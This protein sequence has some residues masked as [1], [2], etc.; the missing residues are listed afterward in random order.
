[1]LVPHRLMR[2]PI[3][4]APVMTG[5]ATK[6]VGS[7]YLTN[8]GQLLCRMATAEENIEIVRQQ[9]QAF[10]RGDIEEM[11]SFWAAES[12]NHGGRTA[13]GEVRRPMPVGIDGVKRVFRSL[14]TAFPDRAHVV[15]DIFATG[16]RVVCR[17]TMR[18]TH[19]GVP[20]FPVEGGMLSTV[21][22]TGKSYE[23]QHIHIFRMAEGKITE[24]W[25]ARDD[26][27]L[28]QQLGIVP[29]AEPPSHP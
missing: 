29:M 28:M 6:S 21:P 7:R 3:G 25:A 13:A 9:W 8:S 5:W 2:Q 27:G 20:E 18:G 4:P 24:H 1:M 17:M 23:I 15:E 26:L 10:D 14:R 22:P 11:A 19:Q 16:D 12:I